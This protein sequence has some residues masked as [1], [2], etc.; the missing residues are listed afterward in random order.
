MRPQITSAADWLRHARAQTLVLATETHKPDIGCRSS[1]GWRYGHIQF[2]P[3]MARNRS[4]E[5]R[6]MTRHGQELQASGLP[7]V[8]I[9]Q[10][11]FLRLEQVESKKDHQQD[12]AEATP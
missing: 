2:G 1:L 12:Q 5:Y 3:R 10:V 7:H 8:P 4:A 6:R 11:R 9:R